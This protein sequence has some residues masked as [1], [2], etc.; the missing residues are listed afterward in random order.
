M[1]N[2]LFLDLNNF[3]ANLGGAER[4]DSIELNI[5]LL[6]SQ[7][8]SNSKFRLLGAKSDGKFVEQIEGMNLDE[9][10]N[11]KIILEEQFV[12][13]EGIVKMELNVVSRETETTTKEFY[14]FVSNTMNGEIVESADS[15][16]TLE[17]VSKYVDDAVNNLDALKEA[18]EDITIINSEFKEN[19]IKRKANEMLREKN[20]KARL[21]SEDIR[22]TEEEERVAN[23][24][25]RI[26]AEND[27]KVS[28]RNR[29]L[30]ENTRKTNEAARVE[31]ELTRQSLFE[32]NEEIRNEN[33]NL[34]IAS[35]KERIKF[36]NKA[37]TDEVN[38]KEA[39][40]K[41]VEAEKTRV[42]AEDERK[43]A[44]TSRQEAE[45]IRQNTYTNF[46]EAEEERRNNEISRQEAEALRI[47]AE[48]RRDDLY[49]QKE[50]E[51]NAAFLESERT[52]GTAFNE[53]QN[54]RNL[55][56]EESER[57]R[58]EAFK[59]SEAARNEA[60]EGRVAAE[61]LRAE[62]EKL[63]VTGEE[64]RNAT[65]TQ[66]EEERKTAFEEAEN[67]RKVAESK[68][69]KTESS[70]VEAEK[71]RVTAEEERASA[72]VVREEKIEEFGSQV[73]KIANDFDEAVAN[74]TNGNES[75]TNSEIVQARGGK[76]NLNARLDNFD[77]QFKNVKNKTRLNIRQNNKAKLIKYNPPAGFEWK[78]YP[79]NI[80]S[81]GY[82]FLS[83][84]DVSE[85]KNES[86]KII[87]VDVIG[88]NNGNDGLNKNTPKKT[89][90][91]AMTLLD[92][93]DT[94]LIT[95]P[96]GTIYYPSNGGF[97][98]KKIT[99]SCN[100]IAENKVKI[101]G[102][103]H[104][105]HYTSENG[106]WRYSGS[107]GLANALRV[108]D[109]NYDEIIEYQK[110]ST[111]LDC[112]SN[113]GTYYVE[114]TNLYINTLNGKISVDKI[115]PICGFDLLIN[116]NSTQ[117]VKLYV[118]NID[119]IG[120][121]S[122]CVSITNTPSFTEPEFYAKKCSFSYNES[123]RGAVN[124]QGA[125]LC[126]SQQCI[127]HDGSC[128]GFGYSMFNNTKPKI[129]EINC[130][131]YNNGKN[132]KDGTDNTYNGSTIHEGCTIIRIN[133]KYYNNT[134]INVADVGSATNNFNS[135]NLNCI[136]FDSN[137]SSKV[138]YNCGFMNL[139]FGKMWLDT[140]EGFGS[141]YDVAGANIFTRNCIFDVSD[142]T[143]EY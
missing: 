125:K 46:N 9:Q 4:G 57:V 60:E 34:R 131:S 84:T 15:I 50:E 64:N 139:G 36:N 80:F 94:I 35:E 27:R 22:I 97:N 63:R 29:K 65:F 78:D 103:S 114:D 62:A 105:Y 12:N 38:R 25:E 56:F 118:E 44:E 132:K 47:E 40:T 106:V 137:S 3:K 113:K 7:D 26:Q 5:K 77:S 86:N 24:L 133:G 14:F 110:V 81:D 128:D 18:S 23:E 2:K 8:Y 55:T 135:L 124:I 59:V 112:Q 104:S 138:S 108:V 43:K 101:V 120:G 76:I 41:R 17:K 32:E 19:E 117:N 37:K 116:D 115:L 134:G 48:K 91:S 141:A 75:A 13:C 74:V 85:F 111:L 71:L 52:R 88:G 82:N 21:Q 58:E 16:P 6:N 122:G 69:V 100:L 129:I 126:I 143:I 121:I 49:S 30:S 39:E 99:K 142:P 96:E 119:F 72:E 136:A 53:A 67:A 70:R 61:L 42:I 73:T 10:S 89:L 31:A 109:L 127:V 28:E 102:A 93:G 11:L 90:E 83:L 98:G 1:I 33:E 107:I 87:Y 54:D 123:S 51:R 95:S 140:C 79:I 68:R 45:D 130:V 66:S 92:D 20:E